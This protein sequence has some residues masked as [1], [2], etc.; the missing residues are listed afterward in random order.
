MLLPSLLVLSQIG[1]DVPAE[2]FQMSPVDQMFVRMGAKD[3]IMAGQSTFLTE[4][5]ETAS[6][7]VSFPIIMQV[8]PITKK[9]DY[10]VSFSEL[11]YE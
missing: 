5:L 9:R 10:A 11:C 6:M 4:L 8:N 2:N 7:L 3:H 1:A